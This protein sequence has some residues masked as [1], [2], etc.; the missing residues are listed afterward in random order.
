M[1]L[2]SYFFATDHLCHFKLLAIHRTHDYKKKMQL[3]GRLWQLVLTCPVLYIPR[4]SPKI[5]KLRPDEVYNCAQVHLVLGVARLV[6]C[7]VF[8]YAL[9]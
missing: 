2:I 5:Q 1:L 9:A 7:G 4:R 3:I 8:Q 6:H